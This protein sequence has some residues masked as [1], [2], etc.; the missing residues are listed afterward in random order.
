M[1]WPQA[2]CVLG[3][4]VVAGIALYVTAHGEDRELRDQLDALNEHVDRMQLVVDAAFRWAASS[5]G[6]DARSVD[7]LLDALYEFE[8]FETE[9]RAH[10]GD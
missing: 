6:S 10:R 2:V 9:V 7:R 4:F 1:S 5:P 8:T 3:V